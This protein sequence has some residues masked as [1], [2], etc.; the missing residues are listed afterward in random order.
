MYHIRRNKTH[1]I[2]YEWNT[3]PKQPTYLQ[4]ICCPIG[5][6]NTEVGVGRANI[7]LATLW[8]SWVRFISLNSLKFSGS[9]QPI[10]AHP[11]IRKYAD[12][13]KGIILHF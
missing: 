10:K 1:S 8:L 5:S 7:N 6:P 4:L 11:G 2:V 3:R 12:G 13:T 9:K